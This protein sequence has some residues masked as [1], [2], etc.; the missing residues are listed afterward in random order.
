MRHAV[1]A[2][3]FCGSTARREPAYRASTSPPIACLQEIAPADIL[4]ARGGGKLDV[5]AHEAPR[6]PATCLIAARMRV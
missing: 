2:V 4:D 5:R 3:F 6:S 1:R